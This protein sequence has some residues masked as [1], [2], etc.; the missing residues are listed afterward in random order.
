MIRTV[1]EVNRIRMDF[2]G[3]L[4][5][6]NQ[7]NS[8]DASSDPE[9]QAEVE[10]LPNYQKII[11]SLPK[12]YIRS[13]SFSDTNIWFTPASDENGV[14]YVNQITNLVMGIAFSHLLA[15]SRGTACRGGIAIGCGTDALGKT[16]ISQGDEVY[17]PVLWE[18]YQ[19][20]NTHAIYPRVVVSDDLVKFMTGLKRDLAS[21]KQGT[22]EFAI[23]VH[24]NVH[25]E[26]FRD[27]TSMDCD[28][29]IVVDYAGELASSIF[30][31]VL[32]AEGLNPQDVYHNAI[33]FVKSELH[34]FTDERNFKLSGRYERAYRYLESCSKYWV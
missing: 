23:G 20:E 28:R 2:A 3:I 1:Q 21:L 11:E 7:V 15:L 8:G 12:G 29:A 16:D 13:Q 5:G 10:K 34:R 18:A 24:A 25:I 6:L 22:E 30:K 33:E 4:N 9:L 32:S 26:A 17:G 31:T 19:L 27:L 14:Q